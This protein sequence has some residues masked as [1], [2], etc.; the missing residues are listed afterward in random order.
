MFLR[1]DETHITADVLKVL[2]LTATRAECI[3]RL[4]GIKEMGFDEV[5][6]HVVPGHEDDMLR[7]WAEVM[8]KV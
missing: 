5:Q 7:R 8:A 6:F 1:P 3:E 2:T 4:R